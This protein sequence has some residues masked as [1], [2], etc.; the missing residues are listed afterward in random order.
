METRTA[1]RKY[2]DFLPIA[3]RLIVIFLAGFAAI[4]LLKYESS[5]ALQ[6]AVAAIAALFVA[7]ELVPHAPH[8]IRRPKR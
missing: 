8:Y 3:K 5:P 7:I 4:Q 6:L 2:S 1:D